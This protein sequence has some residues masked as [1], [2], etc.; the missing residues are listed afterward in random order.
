MKDDFKIRAYTPADKAGLIE[1]LKLN[2]PQNFDESQIDDLVNYL[3]NQI[4]A[5]FVIE[6]K[7][8]LIGGGGINFNHYNQEA[9]ISWDFIHPDLH[10]EGAGKKLLDYRIDLLKSMDNIE[11]ITVRTSQMAYQFYEKYG[12]QLQDIMEDHWAKG[13]DL[14]RMKYKHL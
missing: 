1:V 3:D 8:K 2:I 4:E 7:G 9:R 11:K 14:Y 13:F 6:R 5:Y 12:F 10:G